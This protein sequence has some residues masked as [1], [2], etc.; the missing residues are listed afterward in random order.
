MA[1]L[2][3]SEPTKPMPEF[4]YEL[5]R[6][7]GAEAVA[8][9]LNWR[10]EWHGSFTPVILGAQK[11]FALLTDVWD[12]TPNA[13]AQAIQ[14]SKIVDL[15][16]WFAQRIEDEELLDDLTDAS[17]WNTRSGA[18]SNFQTI[19]DIL[20]GKVH[21]WVYVA[22]IPTAIS[23]EVPAYLRL[24]GW[25]ACPGA[26]EQVAIWRYWQEKYGAEI[27]CV[28]GDVIEAT[29]ARPPLEKEECY[30][31]AREQFSY[32][33]DIVTQ[34]VGTIDALATILRGGKSWYFWWD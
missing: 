29:V 15:Q 26:Q 34:G 24:G 13:P 1:I 21:P 23:Y 22:K 25:N 8:Q 6:V 18:G 12:E 16:K 3:P 27:L 20:T 10:K 5:I 31:L 32:C 33:E 28:T 11:D 17:A 4:P 2:E 9:C 19:H 30:A 7:K 14:Y